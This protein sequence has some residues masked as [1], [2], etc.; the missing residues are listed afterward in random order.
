MITPILF[1][2]KFK[3]QV[4]IGYIEYWVKALYVLPNRVWDSTGDNFMELP[5]TNYS[6]IFNS[7]NKYGIGEGVSVLNNFLVNRLMLKIGNLIA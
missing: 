6:H 4:T 2:K 7:F 5:R 3:N 1:E